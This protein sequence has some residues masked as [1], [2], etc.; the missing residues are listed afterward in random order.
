MERIKRILLVNPV[1]S[2]RGL[3]T[4][5]FTKCKPMALGV[6]A[7]LTPPGVEIILIDENYDCFEE[8]IAL[9]GKVDLAGITAFTSTVTRG[10][11][12]ASALKASGVPVVMGGIHVSFN[13]EEALKYCDSVVIGEAEGVW[14]RLL[15]DADGGGLKKVYKQEKEHGD[16]TIGPFKNSIFS[17][18]YFWGAVQTSRGCPMNCDFCTVTIFNGFKYRLRPI[19]GIITEL[20]EIKQKHVFFYDDNIVGRTKEQ[21]ARAV[22]LFK[23]IVAEGIDKHWFC[24]CSINVGEDDEVLKWM[25][26]SGCRMMLVGFES[27]D[28]DNLKSMNKG[29]NLALLKRYPELI[30]RIH[31]H[32]IAVLGSFMVGYPYDS[33]RTVKVLP[34]FINRMGIDAFQLTHLTPFPGTKTYARF[35]EEG[36][37]TK[38]DYPED[39]S[40]YNFSNVVYR[41]ETLTEEELLNIVYG[42]KNALTLPMTAVLGRFF[43]TLF[44]T[45]SFS[46]ALISFLWNLGVRRAYVN[47]IKRRKA[48]GRM[49]RVQG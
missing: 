25:Y 23:R 12:I 2:Q 42:V 31:S 34:D 47:G 46:T 19:G 41:H 21:K 5:S 43:K 4:T 9:A 48:E 8:K 28:G 15:L 20:K 44:L 6:L 27:V 1:N 35:L 33:F 14:E 39:W 49:S 24:Q 37:I 30:G 26:R 36:R 10:Y 3:A 32:G 17:G 11:E 45:R 13:H 29:H 22:E 16:V 38:M 40:K 7:G 18:K